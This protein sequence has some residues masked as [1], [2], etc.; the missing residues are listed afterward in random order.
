MRTWATLSVLFFSSC[1]QAV[2]EEFDAGSSVDASMPSRVEP[3]PGRCDWD[4]GGLGICQ[5]VTAYVF[6]G[7]KCR[8]VCSNRQPGEPGVFETTLECEFFCVTDAG[9]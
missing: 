9:P 2:P 3:T 5:A 8:P 6:D 1:L 4:G 7:S